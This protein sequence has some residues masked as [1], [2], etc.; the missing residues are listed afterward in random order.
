LNRVFYIFFLICC[1]SCNSENAAP[2]LKTAGASATQEFN[3]DAFDQIRVAG[4]IQLL[5]RQGEE[6]RVLVKSGKNVIDEVQLEVR[7]SVLT[8]RYN[9]GCNLARDYG[10]TK[11]IVTTPRLT[12]VR[13]ASVYDV[14]GE[15]TLSFPNLQLE[16]NTL[17]ADSAV[18]YNSGGFE[19]TLDAQQIILSAN[20]K[21][22]F[23]LKGKTARLNVNFAD[24]TARL[25]SQELIAQRVEVFHRSAN[26]IIVNPQ[27]SLNGIITG[28][29][30]IIS[31]NRPPSVEVIERFTGKLIFETN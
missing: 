18:F 20:G 12:R 7:D 15:G 1:V 10:I 6:Q 25:E 9:D 4:D 23:K 11:L 21:A 16:S 14:V 2:C 30:D 29:G 26:K 5:L 28:S 13:N 8:A 17:D 27:N 22:F 3:L 31:V 24:K 19:L